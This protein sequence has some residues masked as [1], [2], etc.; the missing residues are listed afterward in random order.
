MIGDKDSNGDVTEI[1][2]FQVVDS[3]GNTT[4]TGLN[5]NN[6]ITSARHSSG[7]T[8]NFNWDVDSNYTKVRVTV[9]LPDTSQQIIINIEYCVI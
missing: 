6:T 9:V 1:Q 2:S 3:E 8:M 5:E 7:M 4:Y